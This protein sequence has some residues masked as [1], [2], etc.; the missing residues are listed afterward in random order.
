MGDDWGGKIASGLIWVF[1]LFCFVGEVFLRTRAWV[2]TR[3]RRLPEP[4]ICN[5]GSSCTVKTIWTSCHTNKGLTVVGEN[6]VF[7]RLSGSLGTER[8]WLKAVD[9]G[10]S[11]MSALITHL[12]LCAIL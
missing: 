4:L 10:H 8:W 7:R 11:G 3:V 6:E 2:W 12:F 9:V 5:E 1:F